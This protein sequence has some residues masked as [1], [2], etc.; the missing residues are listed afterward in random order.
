MFGVRGKAKACNFVHNDEIWKDHVNSEL[1]SQRR[2]PDK[3]GFLASEYRQL[4]RETLKIG[5]DSEMDIMEEE[6]KKEST[7]TEGIEEKNETR[8]IV[9][10][11]DKM[12]FPGTSSQ[13]IGW[14]RE[15]HRN[16]VERHARGKQDIVKLFK[17]PRE[18]V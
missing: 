18:G 10:D 3:W 4:Q 9:A 5:L 11:N 2:W 6:E 12:I 8:K 17:W 16:E 1:L 13:M 14:R 15:T 7:S